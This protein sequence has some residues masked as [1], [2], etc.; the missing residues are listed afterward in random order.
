M[1]AL[2]SLALGLPLG[3]H[4]DSTPQTT[5]SPFGVLASIGVGARLFV[6]CH[7]L[8]VELY[9]PNMAWLDIRSIVR[10]I[11]FDLSC[12][13]SMWFSKFF[14]FFFGPFSAPNGLGLEFGVR[15]FDRPPF[16]PSPAKFI[17]VHPFCSLTKSATCIPLSS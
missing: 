2:P 6:T 12:S 7:A 15:S 8:V 13:P 17:L 5:H 14:Y 10:L 9:F 1:E 16:G 11:M 4:S 3:F